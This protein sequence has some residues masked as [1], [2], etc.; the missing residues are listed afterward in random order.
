MDTTLDE[1]LA[2]VGE[3]V[4]ESLAFMFVIDEDELADDSGSAGPEA[5]VRVSFSGPL[6]GTLYLTVP[7]EMLQE[8]TASMLG[9]DDE[10]QACPDAGLDALKELANVIC[11][12]LLPAIA[13]SH[14]IFCVHRPEAV[15]H[16]LTVEAAAK[17]TPTARAHLM[18][19]EGC[20]DLALFLD[21]W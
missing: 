4:F 6:A 17:Q 15:A 1:T 18:L 10:E 19:D 5:A 13:G 9:T 7:V 12:N 2:Q 21:R 16:G 14:A 8:L 11:G 3:E 20:V